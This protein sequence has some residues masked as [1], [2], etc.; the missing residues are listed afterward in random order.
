MTEQ[1]IADLGPAF[2]AYLGQYRE[3]IEHYTEALEKFPDSYKL[4]R[5][6]GHRYITIREFEK[7]EADLWRA[8]QLAAPHPDAPE[9][10]GIPN[11]RNEPRSTTNSNIWY[12]L[13]LSRYLQGE[14]AEAAHAWEW[15]LR[16]S[17]NDDMIVSARY[18]LFLSRLREG[19]EWDELEQILL[20]I[21]EDMDIVENHGY[22]RL[23]LLFLGQRLEE[24]LMEG[25]EPGGV[26]HATIAYG[27]ARARALEGDEA[28]CRELLAEIV[29][30]EMWPAF[31]HIAADA[32]LAKLERDG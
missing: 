24:D 29:E 15:C 12:H 16:F 25:L 11:E 19:R 27:V 10:D 21:D 7:A 2:A 20:P 22:H 8:A 14:Y 6:R 3:A 4:L 28:G 17:K 9:P 32:D 5:H 31:G 26:E 23:L 13:A 30:G 18:W 1:A